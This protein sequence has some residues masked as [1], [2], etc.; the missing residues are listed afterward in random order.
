LHLLAA[1]FA[2]LRLRPGL[3]RD[4]EAEGE[5]LGQDDGCDQPARLAAAGAAAVWRAW[6]ER[7][8]T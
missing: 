5:E 2:S 3:T 6:S 8:A 1:D 4:G 7:T